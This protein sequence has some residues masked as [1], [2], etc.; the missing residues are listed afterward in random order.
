MLSTFDIHVISCRNISL[1]EN[2][3]A[4]QSI[5]IAS[6]KPCDYAVMEKVKSMKC[7]V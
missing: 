5:G 2:R 7:F 3:K 6:H 4:N 1:S